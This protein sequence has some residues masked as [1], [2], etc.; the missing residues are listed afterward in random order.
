[1]NHTQMEQLDK[2]QMNYI[3]KMNP[4]EKHAFEIAKRQLKSSFSLEK[5][6]GYLNDTIQKVKPS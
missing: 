3:E 2:K 5:S 6:I 4:L 1:M